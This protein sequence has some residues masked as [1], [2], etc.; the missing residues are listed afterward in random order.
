MQI[1]EAGLGIG[2]LRGLIHQCIVL[3]VVVL[4][5]VVAVGAV[6]GLHDVGG[7]VI[8]QQPAVAADFIIARAA[9]RQEAR[10]F[11]DVHA[12]GE[13][14]FL[15][16][17]LHILGNRLVEA[18]SVDGVMNGRE[19]FA[20]GV[21][22]LGQKFL[23]L[24]EVGFEIAVVDVGLAA[25]GV[26]RKIAA[27]PIRDAGAYKAGSGR[28]RAGHDGLGDVVTVDRQAQRRTHEGIGELGQFVVHADV[29]G[30]QHVAKVIIFPG[31]QVGD[32]R[33]REIL[34][35]HGLACL[36]SVEGSVGI[37]NEQELESIQL[38][39]IRI[40]VVRVLS[41]RDVGGGDPFADVEGAVADVRLGL[42]GPGVAVGFDG[43]PVYR[44]KYVESGQLIEIRAHTGKLNHE[45]V[46]VGRGHGQRI[47]VAAC[48]FF[49]ALDHAQHGFR[50]GGSGGGIGHALKAVDEVFSGQGRAVGP[51]QAFAQMER[52]G[53]AI[54]ADIK[55][56]RGSG[57]D[58]VVLVHCQQAIKREQQHVAAV[59]RGI[60][61]G[62]DRLG[63]GAD[64]HD[65]LLG[66]RVFGGS[67]GL[68]SS[69]L[70]R[71]CGH[72]GGGSVW[73]GAAGRDHQGQ[74]QN[75]CQQECHSSLHLFFLLVFLLDIYHLPR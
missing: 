58:L 22:S 63:V 32:F 5:V 40:P 1:T 34:D 48:R 59:Y 38:D 3:G 62:V 66:T 23:G 50:I 51:L 44:S 24:G 10:P 13:A 12:H 27:V 52:I 26:G 7:I 20:I 43:S 42:G 61:R 45:G 73:S 21:A 54:R 29:V 41:V 30:A 74:D 18:R 68:G 39:G 33:A 9:L 25:V 35:H 8:V 11:H 4:G 15:P 71:R 6:H 37:L 69:V 31:L 65:E 56:F 67:S 47:R 75:E 64:G 70:R 28:H 19:A 17:L 36:I 46:G 53:Q 14:E 49:K 2:F 72:V 55:G 60:E 16:G 57:D